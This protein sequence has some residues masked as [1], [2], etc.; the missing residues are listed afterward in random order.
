MTIPTGEF[1]YNEI[2][3]VL[4]DISSK[5]FCAI[6]SDHTANIVLAK[7]LIADKYPYILP[8]RCIAHHI[9]LLTNDIMKL[10]WAAKLITECKKIVTFF[11]QSHIAGELLREEIIKNLVKGGG[12]KTHVKTRWTT[13]ID[14]T[15]SIFRCQTEIRN[16]STVLIFFIYI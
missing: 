12:L 16:V 4:E 1:L 3:Q 14:C 10:D 9:N 6:V 8:M 13:A 2:S 7:K 5:K 15:D 11:K